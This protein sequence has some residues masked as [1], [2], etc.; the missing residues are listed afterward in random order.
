[1]FPTFMSETRRNPF[2][3]YITVKSHV[4][5]ALIQQPPERSKAQYEKEKTLNT[6][7]DMRTV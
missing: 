5:A 2:M 3:Q 4:A 7:T 6:K 1:M